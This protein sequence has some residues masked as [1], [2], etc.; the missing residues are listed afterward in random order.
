V[1]LPA[2]GSYFLTLAAIDK[3]GFE[4]LP[5][6][7]KAFVVRTSPGAP[8]LTIPQKARF[9]TPSA[10][11][12]WTELNEAAGYHVVVAQDAGFTKPLS[13]A[14]VATPSWN[15]P[16]LPLGLY[17]VRVQSVA[18]DGFQS[19]WS[20]PAAFTIAEPPRLLDNE[21]AA[22]SSILLRWNAVQDGDTYDLQVAAEPDFID[23]LVVSAEGLRH[24]EYSLDNPLKPGVYYL[25]VRGN[26]PDGSQSS[27]GPTQ[28]III[29]PAPMTLAEKLILG[30]LALCSI[31]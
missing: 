23:T 13:E 19:A 26:P 30:V 10:S 1:T 27:W 17:Y 5:T 9:L 7:P 14:T 21:L 22:G 4:S 6:S 11:L 25:R 31:L 3:A 16:D 15:T 28:K 2:D 20:E 24:P 8:I 12:S 18:A 29:H